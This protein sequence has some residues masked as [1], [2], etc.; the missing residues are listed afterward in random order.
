MELG[1][2]VYLIATVVAAIVVF[3]YFAIIYN[4]LIEVRNNVKMCWSNIDVLCKQRHDEIP[5]LVESCKQYMGYEQETLQQVIAARGAVMT[6]LG[7]E[8]PTE[9]GQAESVLRRSM[10]GLFALSE[11][12]PDLKANNSFQQLQARISGLESSISDKRE[13]YNEAV[14]TNNIK[15][16]QFPNIMLSKVCGFGSIDLLKFSAE[17]TADVNIKSLFQ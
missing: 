7:H 16:K 2:N 4:M 6:A 11:N 8:N 13:L 1:S 9:L 14:N 5:K 10:G 12:Y 3:V 17:E 15:I